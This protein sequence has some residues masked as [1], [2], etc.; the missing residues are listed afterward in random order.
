M[1]KFG[2]NTKGAGLRVAVV[3]SRFNPEITAGLVAGAMD[4]LNETGV[5]AD[6]ITLIR[7]P[8][9]FEIP[10]A[11]KKAAESRR[12]DGVIAIGCVIRGETAHFEYISHHATNGI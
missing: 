12:F 7:V 5:A 11:A 3:S 9:A 6:D 2:G 4:A 1:N 8:G 10:L